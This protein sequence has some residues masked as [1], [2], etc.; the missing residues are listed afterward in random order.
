MSKFSAR[1][2]VSRDGNGLAVIE[3]TGRCYPS[4]RASIEANVTW[5]YQMIT[6]PQAAGAVLKALDGT[7]PRVQSVTP[8]TF[9]SGGS[10]RCVKVAAWCTPFAPVQ[11]G[12][13]HSGQAILSYVIR[14]Q[15][16]G[17]VA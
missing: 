15:Q 7:A 9:T 6:L 8:T 3:E 10:F 5:R 4:D 14:Y 2:H 11:T 1:Y 13:D 16:V 12:G 17:G